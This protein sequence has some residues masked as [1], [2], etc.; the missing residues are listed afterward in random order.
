MRNNLIKLRVDLGLTQ[1]EMGSLVGYTRGQW[2]NVEK[3]KRKGSADMWFALGT[4]LG[5][6]LE[7]IKKLKEVS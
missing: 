5:L 7:Q 2:C 1:Q 3:A 4:K 6:T